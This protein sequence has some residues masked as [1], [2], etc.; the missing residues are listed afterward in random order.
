MDRRNALKNIG[1]GLGTIT[2]TPSILNLFQS[3]Q[4]STTLNSVFFNKEQFL[5]VSKLMEIIIPETETPGAISLKLPEFIDAYIYNVIDEDNITSN[6]ILKE[7]LNKFIDLVKSETTKQETNEISIKEWEDQLRKVLVSESKNDKI[8]IAIQDLRKLTVGAYKINEFVGENLMAYNPVP[9][10][11][12]GCVDLN[13][14]TK[15]VVWSGT[16]Q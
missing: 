8:T 2:I 6:K 16:G 11:Q 1:K 15:G 3:C 7:G 4:N 9:G 12:I 10:K 5:V 14:A 13:E